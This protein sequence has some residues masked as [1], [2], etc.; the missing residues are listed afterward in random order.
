MLDSA[1][2]LRKDRIGG[3]LMFLIGSGAI[4][5][6]RAYDIGSLHQMGPGF[7][8]AALGAVLA[9]VGLLI[10]LSA[11]PAKQRSDGQTSSP[12]WRVWLLIVA[13][14]VSFVLLGRYAGLL[15]ASFAVTFIAA[16]ADRQ[17]NLRSAFWLALTM[18]AIAIVVF[19]WALQMQ[20]PL[21][22][23]G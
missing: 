6:A 14:L 2:D 8:P 21:L 12:E 17:N 16:L 10:A 20:F 3:T 18:S 11:R 13:S 22:R 5:K 9:V 1:T 23:W 7:F 19:W 15:P 4:V